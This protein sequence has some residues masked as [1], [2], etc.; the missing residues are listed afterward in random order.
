MDT[1]P[2]GAGLMDAI[3]NKESRPSCPLKWSS[4]FRSLFRVPAPACT[5]TAFFDAK[6]GRGFSRKRLLADD[7]KLEKICFRNSLFLNDFHN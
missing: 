6:P 3:P 7:A 4:D 1:V 2:F 5:M